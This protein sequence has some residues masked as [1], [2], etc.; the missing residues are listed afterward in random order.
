MTCSRIQPKRLADLPSHNR[1]IARLV[2]YFGVATCLGFGK[3]NT[4]QFMH[5]LYGG[6]WIT[7]PPIMFN[8]SI[9]SRPQASGKRICVMRVIKAAFCSGACALA[10]KHLETGESHHGGSQHPKFWWFIPYV[11]LTV[12]SLLFIVKS[13]VFYCKLSEKNGNHDPWLMTYSI[14]LLIRWRCIGRWHRRFQVVAPGQGRALH[15]IST[16]PQ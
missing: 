16:R 11:V 4:S 3:K 14:P 2:T 5:T 7:S 6:C 1:G 15:T 12:K 10:W 9:V 8:S 13:P